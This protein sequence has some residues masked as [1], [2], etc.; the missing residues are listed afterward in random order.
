MKKFVEP[1]IEILRLNAN[2]IISTSTVTTI[3]QIDCGGGVGNQTN[4]DWD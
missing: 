1:E 3:P 2:N 4:V